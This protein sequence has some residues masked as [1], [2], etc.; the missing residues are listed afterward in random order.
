MTNNNNLNLGN[1]IMTNLNKLRENYSKIKN[2]NSTLKLLLA[3]NEKKIF[4]GIPQKELENLFEDCQ[5]ELLNF[6][7]ENSVLINEINFLDFFKKTEHD[8]DFIIDI[9]DILLKYM[10]LYFR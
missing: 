2:L 8:E 10:D 1:K 4:L 7:L 3:M 5:N 6:Q 9:N